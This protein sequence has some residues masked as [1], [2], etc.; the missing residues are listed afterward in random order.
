M[1]SVT[2]VYAFNGSGP[3]VTSVDSVDSG[4]FKFGRDDSVTSTSP[5]P[6]PTTT[7]THFSYLKYL[8]LYTVSSG[9]A[10]SI[11]N[12]KV[13]LASALATGLAVWW[14]ATAAY[15]Q[16]AGATGTTVGDYPAD[17][18][19]S[20]ATPASP[21]AFTYAALTTTPAAYDS[22]TVLTA[23]T[24]LNGKYV[25]FVLAVADTYAGGGGP[26]TLPN[27]IYTYDEA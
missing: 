8:G 15:V 25:V 11:S 9:G 19:S 16:N 10:T 7:G 14:Y 3:T 24:A 20:G 12:R 13:S 27:V 2:K 22:S 5:L 21:G 23:N 4:S 17:S 6:I 1:A 26:A 18:G